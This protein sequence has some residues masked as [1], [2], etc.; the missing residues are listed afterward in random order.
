[1]TGTILKKSNLAIMGGEPV[2]EK[3]FPGHYFIGDEE[4]KAVSTFIDSRKELSGFL[5]GWGDRF[6]GGEYVKKFENEWSNYVK[7]KF[8]VSFNS[9]TSGLCAAI[10]AADVGP[11]D[12]V[13]V[14][15]YSMSATATAILAYQ[16]IPVFADIN[17]KTFTLDPNSIKQ[18]ITSRTKAIMTTAIFGHPSDMDEILKLAKDKNIIVIEDTAQAPGAIYNNTLI[19]GLA[20]MSVFSLNV[21]KHIHS[22]E[23]G[24]VTTNVEKFAHKLKLIRNHAEAVIDGNGQ[25]D[26]INCV[27]FNLRFTEIAAIIASEQLKKLPNLLDQRIENANFLSKELSSLPGIEGT[28]VKKNCKHVYYVQPMLFDENI[29]GVKRD[30]FISAVQKELPKA[31]DRPDGELLSTGFAKPIYLLPL[32]QKKIAYG[33]NHWPFS[34]DDTSMKIDYSK[35]ICP[36]TEDIEENKM[37]INDYVRPPANIDDMKD[38]VNA[39]VKVYENKKDLI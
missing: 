30:V 10:G 11:G 36:V 27:G 24:M 5:G 34:Y 35:G 25:E 20:D 21:H 12:E 23:G 1:V 9:N 13:I 28:F 7:T 16:G 4:K 17:T 8:T 32:F 15:P 2:R 31:E 26:L 3:L 33:A 39:F 22:G 29:V 38:V 19:G 6:E 37:F 14:T 18:K